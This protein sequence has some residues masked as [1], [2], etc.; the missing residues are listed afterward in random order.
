MQCLGLDA[1]NVSLHAQEGAS[2]TRVVFGSP[3]PLPGA[4]EGPRRWIRVTMKA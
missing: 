1:D 3:A 4:L 2:G